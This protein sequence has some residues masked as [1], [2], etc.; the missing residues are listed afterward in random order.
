M[1][2]LAIGLCHMVLATITF[3]VITDLFMLCAHVE[4][5]ILNIDVEYLKTTLMVRKLCHK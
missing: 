1:V 3:K 2:P 5:L 4:Q